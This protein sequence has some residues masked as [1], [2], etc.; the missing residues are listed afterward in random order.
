ML[1]RYKISSDYCINHLT[2]V[3]VDMMMDRHLRY[4]RSEAHDSRKSINK[5]LK[6]VFG[7]FYV[8]IRRGTFFY[9][10]KGVALAFAYI[11]YFMMSFVYR[12]EFLH[13]QAS[14]NY[15][16]ISRDVLVD[17]DLHNKNNI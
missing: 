16:K 17:W 15:D 7:A 8:V 12:W 9:G 3:S 4:W 10:Y 6:S 2:H 1:L 5:S 13:S 14:Q 11:S